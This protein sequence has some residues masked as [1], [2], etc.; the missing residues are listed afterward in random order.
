MD[1]TN[2]TALVETFRYYGLAWLLL[3]ALALL[4]CGLLWWGLR[5][6]H[7][8][9]KWLPVSL[10]LAGALTPITA[11]P[12]T[13][14]LAP[15]LSVAIME[16]EQYGVE[17][18]WRGLGMVLV[19]WGLLLVIGSTLWVVLHKRRQ[20]GDENVHPAEPAATRREPDL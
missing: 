8:L 15:A 3:A 14:T 1:L 11:G 7:F 9:I 10:V 12:E 5:Q 2:Q 18:M 19:A 17:G 16:L 4:L 6:R 13:T 20:T